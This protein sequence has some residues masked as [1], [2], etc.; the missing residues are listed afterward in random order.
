[1]VLLLAEHS[2]SSELEWDRMEILIKDIEKIW[3]II[4]SDFESFIKNN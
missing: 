3:E 4:K 1:M 2:Y